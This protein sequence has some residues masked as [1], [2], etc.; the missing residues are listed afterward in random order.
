MSTRGLT[1]STLLYRKKNAQCLKANLH[2]LESLRI[3]SGFLWSDRTCHQRTNSFCIEI[4]RI[5]R[6]NF[7]C[8]AQ[9]LLSWKLSWKIFFNGLPLLLEYDLNNT[10]GFAKPDMIG[11]PLLTTPAMLLNILALPSKLQTWLSF[12]YLLVIED[13]FAHLWDIPCLIVFAWD[14]H[15]PLLLLPTSF[16]LTPHPGQVCFLLT[17]LALQTFPATAFITSCCN[18]ASNYLFPYPAIES[19]STWQPQPHLSCS[20]PYTQCSAR[21]SV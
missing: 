11:P 10:A 19:I 13:D 15:L 20:L 12:S 9:V 3:E 8:Y 7:V 18:I 5:I 16:S 6:I 14:C 17:H 2:Y 4:F 1:F 21:C